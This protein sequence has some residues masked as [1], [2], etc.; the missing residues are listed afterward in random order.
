M[1]ATLLAVIVA[2]PTLEGSLDGEVIRKVIRRRMP[3]IV[4]CYEKFGH[5]PNPRGLDFVIGPSGQVERVDFDPSVG[6]QLAAC[7]RKAIA[8][9]KFPAAKGGGSVKVRYPLLF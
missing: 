1:L 2:Q 6:P 9:T 4:Y 3:A 5:Q 7:L 8:A